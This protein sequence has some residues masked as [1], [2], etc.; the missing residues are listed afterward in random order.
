MKVVV[1]KAG[2]ISLHRHHVQT[3]VSNISILR[4]CSSQSSITFMIPQYIPQLSAVTV[5]NGNV[6]V[7]LGPMSDLSDHN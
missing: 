4:D 5:R 7:L 2:I 6:R 3:G 1:P